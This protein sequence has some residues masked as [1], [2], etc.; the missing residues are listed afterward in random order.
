MTNPISVGPAIASPSAPAI[1]LEKSG[2]SGASGFAVLLE[3]ASSP[4]QPSAAKIIGKTPAAET[5]LPDAQAIDLE[6]LSDALGELLGQLAGL[7]RDIEDELPIE[8]GALETLAG[9][10]ET[11]TDLLDT[12]AIIDPD[13]PLLAQLRD[14]A[15]TLGLEMKA[16]AGDPASV[17]ETLAALATRIGGELRET[18]PELAA[19]LTGLAARLDA[20]AAAIQTA[21]AN[22]EPDAATRLKLVESEAKPNP[23]AMT[24]GNPASENTSAPS[25]KPATDTGQTGRSLTGDTEQVSTPARDAATQGNAQAA[26]AATATGAASAPDASTE[27]PDGLTL[28]TGPA[29]PSPQAHGAARPEAAA[30]TRPE[31]RINVPHIAVEIARS[32]QNGVSRFEIRLNPPELGRVD[33]RIEMDNSGNVVARLAVERS[34][35]LD[36]LQRD[37]RALERALLDA[38]LDG[39]K[40]DLEFSLQQDNGGHDQPDERN[41]WMASVAADPG[42]AEPS[43]P[44]PGTMRGYARLDA[45][46]L[47][48]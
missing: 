34:E 44:S 30:Y 37:Q 12:G 1:A 15:K 4:A 32:I 29:Q 24:G 13:S 33:V 48:V 2:A 35:T 39:G 10:I 26:A 14:I 47:W 22:A 8:G 28:P 6:A 43:I 7:E 45:V 41:R 23:S 40:T 18:A 42:T 9:L 19:G 21:L 31:P 3:G 20:Q 27:A 11:V 36:L 16:D 38:G 25:G 46:N 5:P 17:L